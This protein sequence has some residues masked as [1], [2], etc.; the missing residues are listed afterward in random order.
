MRLKNHALV[1]LSELG[2]YCWNNPTGVFRTRE[3]Q[4][5]KVGTPGAADI[6]GVLHGQAIAVEVKT[7]TGR[8]SDSQKK[9]KAVFERHGGKYIELRTLED[10][11]DIRN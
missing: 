11:N 7:G 5:V 6:L 4:I 9:W 10:L 3:G 1:R 2:A 8:L